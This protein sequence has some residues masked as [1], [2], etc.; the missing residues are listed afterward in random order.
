MKRIPMEIEDLAR[1]R[2]PRKRH[3]EWAVMQF[4]S[5]RHAAGLGALDERRRRGREVQRG[6]FVDPNDGRIV[7]RMGVNRPPRRVIPYGDCL[8]F[9]GISKTSATVTCIEVPA[10]YLRLDIR[11][12]PRDLW[13]Q[14][15]RALAAYRLRNA[16][17]ELRQAVEAESPQQEQR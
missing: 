6:K 17:K 13:D 16:R 12:D 11:V 10:I 5:D 15:G 7:Y 9:P 1:R 14:K 8:D 3:I 2:Y 4:L